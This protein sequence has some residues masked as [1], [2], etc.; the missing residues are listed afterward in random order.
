MSRLKIV[1]SIEHQGDVSKAR[2]LIGSPNVVAS[3]SNFGDILLFDFNSMSLSAKLK[4][5]TEY[6]FGL[7]WQPLDNTQMS[8]ILVSG[9]TDSKIA[10][11]DL[12]LPPNEKDEIFPTNTLTYH[13]Q[14]VNCID[15]SRSNTQLFGSVSDDSQLAIWDLRDLKSPSISFKASHDGLNAIAFNPFC[16]YTFLTGGQERG[17]IWL[18][19]I[20]KCQDVNPIAD[21][22]GHSSCVTNLAFSPNDKNI[23][24]SSAS[25]SVDLAPDSSQQGVVIWD[26]SKIGEELFYSQDEESKLSP[27]LVL[28]HDAHSYWGM[29]RGS[30]EG[31]GVNEEVL[32]YFL[33][34][35]HS[36]V[37]FE[38]SSAYLIFCII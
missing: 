35:T 29:S 26:L 37:C 11:W 23:F 31:E 10:V 19:D 2:S 30:G 33:P 4:A 36:L 38:N 12:T 28:S 16:P 5:H 3:F 8:S 14:A 21:L 9:G 24:C 22:W 17:D 1:K 18:W 32:A 15:F 27:A 13:T 6:G 34:I 20:R 25:V 7:C